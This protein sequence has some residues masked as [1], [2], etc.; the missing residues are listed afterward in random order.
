MMRCHLII[1]IPQGQ[2][3]VMVGCNDFIT[4]HYP[5]S[6]SLNTELIP[7]ASTTLPSNIDQSTQHN[8]L[9]SSGLY[10]FSPFPSLHLH[11]WCLFIMDVMTD[12]KSIWLYVLCISLLA[13]IMWK[14]HAISKRTRRGRHSKKKQEMLKHN[15]REHYANLKKEIKE[16]KTPHGMVKE[17]PLPITP[18]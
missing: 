2:Y 15:H 10:L 5:N 3:D 9:F 4:A 11:F 8:T 13:H 1:N 16:A 18:G 12:P 14:A 17:L 6:D 7:S